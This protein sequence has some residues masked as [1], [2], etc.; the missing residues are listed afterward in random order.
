MRVRQFEIKKPFQVIFVGL[1][2][3][4]KLIALGIKY[5]K[6][7][8]SQT[9]LS[10]QYYGFSANNLKFYPASLFYLQRN[11]PLD[12]SIINNAK[13]LHLLKKNMQGSTSEIFNF[14]LKVMNIVGKLCNKVLDLSSSVTS[15][16]ICGSVSNQ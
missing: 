5:K 12:F 7:L 10:S 3:G 1:F 14:A 13:S 16:E 6:L 2:K 9:L 15:V 8:L 11:L 4:M